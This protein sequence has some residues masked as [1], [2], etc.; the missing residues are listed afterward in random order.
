M[1]RWTAASTG[2]RYTAPPRQEHSHV[3][4]KPDNY[5]SVSPYLIVDGADATI[6]FLKRVFGATEL[7]RGRWP[8]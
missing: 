5:T 8:T 6:Q 3:E 2:P 7:R 1:Q 4:F